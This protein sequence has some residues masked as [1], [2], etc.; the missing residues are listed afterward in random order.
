MDFGLPQLETRDWLVIWA[1]IAG[2]IFAVQAQKWI[3][4]LREARNRKRSLFHTLMATRAARVSPDHVQ[5]LNMIDLVFYGRRILWI[6]YQSKTEKAVLAAWREYHDHLNTHLHIK[7]DD[8]A[9]VIWNNSTEEL[10]IKLLSAIAED[11]RFKF[12]R[13]QLK[14][15]WYSPIAQGE[16]EQEQMII[17]KLVLK[18][19]SGENPL[20]MEVTSFPINEDIA[21]AQVALQKAMSEAFAGK[22]ALNVNVKNDGPPG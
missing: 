6:H 15:G 18:L 22:G 13:V 21:N 3:E 12:D 8:S 10:F 17:R 2:P 1:T 4:I 11:V 20:K 16:L 9:R 19:L 5:A 14:K 7:S